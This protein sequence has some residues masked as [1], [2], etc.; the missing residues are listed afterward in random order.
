MKGELKR[1][2]TEVVM[3]TK[4]GNY[5]DDEDDVQPEELEAFRMLTP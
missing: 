1:L 3:G 4:S 5:M 2:R